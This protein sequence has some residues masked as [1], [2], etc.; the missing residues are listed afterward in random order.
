LLLDLNEKQRLSRFDTVMFLAYSLTLSG[1]VVLANLVL[2]PSYALSNFD[3]YGINYVSILL[4]AIGF[5]ACGIVLTFL[6][7]LRYYIRD[8]LFGYTYTHTD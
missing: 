2:Q 5:F 3:F 8:S 1:M 4:G 6:V 7:F